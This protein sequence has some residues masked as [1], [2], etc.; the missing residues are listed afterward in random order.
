MEAQRQTYNISSPRSPRSTH[1]RSSSTRTSP[2]H[3]R[4]RPFGGHRG[5]N[6]LNYEGPSHPA[7]GVGPGNLQHDGDAFNMDPTAAFLEAGGETYQEPV[8]PAGRRRFVGGFVGGLR[9][10]LQRNNRSLEEEI[11]Y[12]EPAVVNDEE[13]LYESVPRA[14]PEMEYAEPRYASP[15]PGARYASPSPDARYAAGSPEVQ[16]ATPTQYANPRSD[17]GYEREPHRRQES[18][19]T[20]E[21]SDTVHTSQEHYEGTTIVNH[22]MVLPAEQYGS[23]QLVEPQPGSDYAKMDSPPRS[24]ASFGSYVSRVQHFFRAVNALPWIATE[25]VTVDYIPRG[26]A[27]QLPAASG[28]T[29]RPRAARRPMISWYGSDIPQNSIDL[30]SSGSSQLTEF[31]QAQQPFAVPDAASP[32]VAYAS[33]MPVPAKAPPAGPPPMAAATRDMASVPRPHR[34][35]VPRLS[36]E[37]EPVGAGEGAYYAPRYPNGGY[38]PY[39]Q[40]PGFVAPTYTGSSTASALPPVERTPRRQQA[41]PVM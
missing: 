2:R 36:P 5:T 9:K 18:S 37:P 34:V 10:A 13:R 32:G 33:N 4:V 41:T 7:A 27:G 11:T 19:S 23:P 25:R 8:E 35:P 30:F 20:V 3:D 17:E 6:Q 22:D 21:V 31:G 40:Q 26:K 29:P 16:F 1:R 14:E 28:P 12:P 39:D 24:E 15:E 38:V